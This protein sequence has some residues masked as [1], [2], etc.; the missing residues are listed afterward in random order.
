MLES[1][2]VRNL[3][4]TDNFARVWPTWAS[5]LNQLELAGVLTNVLITFLDLGYSVFVRSI[6]FVFLATIEES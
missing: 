3:A 1:T 6:V 5:R 4:R 2:L